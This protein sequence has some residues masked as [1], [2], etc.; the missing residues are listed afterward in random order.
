LLD[1]LVRT[2]EQR[3]RN[4]QAERLRRSLVDPQLELRRLLDGQ[5]AGLGAF[6][7]LVDLIRGAFHEDVK[8]WPVA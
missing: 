2:Q 6:K 1:D 5:V 4:R 8:I 7:D 3:L